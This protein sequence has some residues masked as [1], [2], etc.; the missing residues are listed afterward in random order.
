MVVNDEFVGWPAVIF[1][2]VCTI[3]ALFILLQPNR[4]ELSEHGFTAV[5]L[6]RSWSASW[7]QCGEFRTRDIGSQTLVVFDCDVP[8]FT[9][10]PRLQRL[11]RRLAGANASFPETYGH[12]P[13]D[14]AALLNRYRAA[15][16]GGAG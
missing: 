7:A 12:R 13:R 5:T 6:G 3:V 14:L 8:R 15:A 11:N 2:A 10:R 4:L 16:A 9:R 1:G